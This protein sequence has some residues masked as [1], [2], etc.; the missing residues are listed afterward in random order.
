LSPVKAYPIFFQIKPVKAAINIGQE[1]VITHHIIN[2]L[3]IALAFS[4]LLD[5]KYVKRTDNQP[6]HNAQRVSIP[7]ASKA[8][9]AEVLLISLV[10]Q[11]I[12]FRTALKTLS[13][14][15]EKSS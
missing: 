15:S 4:S 6:V 12:P 11:S 7:N 10:T 13:T 14:F 9:Q 2:D 8:V 5:I 3:I 1:V